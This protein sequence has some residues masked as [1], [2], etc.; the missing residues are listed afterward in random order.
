MLKLVFLFAAGD[1]P[2][3]FLCRIEHIS[4]WFSNQCLDFDQ[5]ITDQMSSQPS[6]YFLEYQTL[7]FFFLSFLNV[8]DLIHKPNLQ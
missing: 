8:E 5:T 1:F 3:P 6:V 7:K 2:E 4:I